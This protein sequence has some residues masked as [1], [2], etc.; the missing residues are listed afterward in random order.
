MILPRK[1]KFALVLCLFSVMLIGTLA[2]QTPAPALAVVHN[3]EG[4]KELVYTLAFSPDGKHLVSGAF[5]K[6][7]KLWDLATGKAVKSYAG[8]T[9][10]VL[11]TAISPDGRIIASGGKDNSIKLWDMPISGE[12]KN[13][14]GSSAG[15]MSQAI[16]PDG[17]RLATGQVDGIIRVWNTSDGKQLGQLADAKAPVMSLAISADAKWL[18]VGTDQGKVFLYDLATLKLASQWQGHSKEV[19]SLAFHLNNQLLFTTGHDGLL[20]SWTV[21][22]AVATSTNGVDKT[23]VA[24]ATQAQDGRWAVGCADKT[25]HILKADGTLEKALPAAEA[26]IK[27]VALQDNVVI[28]GL[29]NNKVAWWDITAGTLTHQVDL[30]K[31]ARSISLRNDAAEFAVALEDGSIKIGEVTKD[32]AKGADKVISKTIPDAGKAVAYHPVNPNQIAVAD[33]KKV[34]KTWLIKEGKAEQTVTLDGPATYISWNKD[35]SRVLATAGNQAILIN[36]KDGKIINKLTH[37]GP[38]VHAGFTADASRVITVTQDGHTHLMDVDNGKEVQAFTGKA[39][40][41][42]GGHSDVKK[43]IVCGKDA[44][45][46]ET[47]ALNR[48]IAASATPV[49]GIA[50][51]DG[52]N[53]AVTAADD[54]I[55]KI[56]N[57]TNGNMDKELKGHQGVIEVVAATPNSQLIFTSG[58]D[59]TLRCFQASDGKELKSIKQNSR[60]LSLAV[61]GNLLVVGMADGTLQFLDVTLTPGQPAPATFCKV[62]QSFKQPNMITSVVMPAAG[63]I[64]YTASTDKSIRSFKVAGDVPTRNLAGHGNLVDAVIFSPDGLSLASCSH[65]GTTRF[66]NLGDGKQTGE[67]KLSP[68]PLY[69]LAWRSD[70]KQLAMGSFDRSIRLIDV[71]G[72]KV[73]R[74]IKGFDEKSS[75]NGHSDAVYTVTYADN[76]Q[77]YSAGSDGK[78]KQWN[79]KDGAMV[80]NFINPALKDK[81]QGDFINNIKLTKDGKKLVAVGNGGWL[82]IWSTPDGKMLHSQRMPVG[83][84]GLAISPDD[85]LIATGNMNGTV[86]VFKMP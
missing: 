55:A 23:T 68:Q 16:T 18:A 38:V 63:V 48:A 36:P 25:I 35:A 58:A 71:A 50:M 20:K 19:R 2:G 47:I 13:Y 53:R 44:V 5:D 61:Q 69:C 12:L 81:A 64:A 34:L 51:M 10:L 28:A 32:K 17:G 66:W 76:D 70:G 59:Q 86:S 62:L 60:V 8:H 41:A 75:P 45:V 4:H 37:A 7:L 73:E 27:C 1:Q 83:L 79:V 46:V 82:T 54:G 24:C 6:E 11:T 85:K 43:I 3:L 15:L 39:A 65:D 42:A 56:F 78:I 72:K 67:V 77:L 9:D 57:L 30:G 80:K 84:Y 22:P 29:V 26:D 14:P 52:G 74:E 31:R 49:R 40:V 21:P 33:D